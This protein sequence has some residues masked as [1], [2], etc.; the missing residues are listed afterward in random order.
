MEK[1]IGENLKIGV[2]GALLFAGNF[3]Y[4]GNEIQS[5]QFY[6]YSEGN[7][8]LPT[9][10]VWFKIRY[11][12]NKGRKSSQRNRVNEDVIEIPKKGF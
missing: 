7:L 12:F 5:N 8:Q 9:L 10:P 6:S 2:T 1:G 11:Q 3:T 4:T